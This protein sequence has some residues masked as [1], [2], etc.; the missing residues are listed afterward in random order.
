MRRQRQSASAAGAELRWSE[1]H[2]EDESVM[3]PEPPSSP[4]PPK[5]GET[6]PRRSASAEAAAL[7]RAEKE[8]PEAD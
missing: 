2:P 3:V 1:K 5:A 4:V 6:R 7:R 8:P